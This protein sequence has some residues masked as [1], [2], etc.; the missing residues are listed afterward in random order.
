[1]ANWLSLKEISEKRGIAESTLRSWKIL[2]YIETSTIDNVVM[3]D[4]DSLIRFL[5]THKTKGLSDEYLKELIKEK[6]REREVILSRY[7]DQLFL[8]KTQELYQPLFRILIK[9]LGALIMDDMQRE[10]FLSISSGEMISRVAVRH[11]ITYAQAVKEYSS[12]LE[13]LSANTERIATYRKQRM[14]QLFGRFNVSD[15]TSIPISLICNTR[16]CNI[17][18]VEG[19]IETVRELLHYANKNG[20]SSLKKLRGMGATT[21]NE[22]I[23]TLCNTH[24]ITKEDR[25]IKLSPEIAALLIE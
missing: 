20:W 5:N 9:E 6:E 12:I 4:D 10:L 17:L 16:A 15:P 24:F 3:I 2:G 8:L 1:M 25:E 11:R 19:K 14:T 23:D 22:L 7:G 13:N 18:H 21:Y